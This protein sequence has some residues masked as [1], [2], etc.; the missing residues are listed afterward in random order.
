MVT[1]CTHREICIGFG[2]SR[3]R[4]TVEPGRDFNSFALRLLDGHKISASLPS[5]SSQ[6]AAY[7]ESSLFQ[8]E[9]GP[10]VVGAGLKVAIDRSS[11]FFTVN[12][13]QLGAFVIDKISIMIYPNDF[14]AL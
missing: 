7:V 9:D 11:I 10:L 12:G 5:T 2:S 14:V 8:C 3:C 6:C 4:Q 1:K 13:R